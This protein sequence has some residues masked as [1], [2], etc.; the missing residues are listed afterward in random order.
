MRAVWT[1]R[2]Q[3]SLFDFPIKLYAATESNSLSLNIIHAACQSRVKYEKR[4]PVHGPVLEGEIGKAYEYEKGKYISITEQELEKIA[5][6][7]DRSLGIQLFV[8]QT[9][10][11]PLIFEKPYYMA[12]DGPIAREAYDTLCQSID[13]S[14]KYGIGKLVMRRKESLVAL[15]V[16][17]KTIVVST[18]RYNN[19]IRGTEPLHE[20]DGNRK[21]NKE[22][23]KMATELIE[24]HTKKFRYK[25]YKDG[26]Q[27]KMITLVKKKVE[28]LRS[29]EQTALSEELA[30]VSSS[31]T[32]ASKKRDMAKAP[33]TTKKQR[34]TG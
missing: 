33:R 25:S 7:S 11:N 4:C 23:I 8:A 34:K 2:L 30:S 29:A 18:L 14:E 19:E 22:D 17:E 26:Y 10:L 31:K 12:P 13:S 28:T 16:K 9:A 5:P 24:R 1:G 6:K 3:F 21:K 32:S 15:W 27:E 20:L